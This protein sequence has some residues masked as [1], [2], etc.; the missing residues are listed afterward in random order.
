MY[1]V[2][3]CTQNN[4]SLLGK[5]KIIFQSPFIKS[6]HTDLKRNERK[7][8]CELKINKK[9]VDLNIYFH[10]NF[11]SSNRVK[12]SYESLVELIHILILTIG[13]YF[14]LYGRF[15]T[16]NVVPWTLFR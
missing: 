15:K 12:V 11:N 7:R 14:R 3:Y 16:S 8:E 10:V 13:T 9:K 2:T 6:V 5:T 1:E 4:K